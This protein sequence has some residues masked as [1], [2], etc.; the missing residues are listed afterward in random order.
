MQKNETQIIQDFI[1]LFKNIDIKKELHLIDDCI[2]LWL[3]SSSIKCRPGTIKYY[4]KYIK[5][6]KPYLNE[7][8]IYYIEDLTNIKMNL[9]ISSIKSL[10]HYKNNTINKVITTLK[11][12]THFCYI[13][14]IIDNDSLKKFQKL[15]KDDE[16]TITINKQ[17]SNKIFNYINSLD[18]HNISNLRN[19]LFIY[20]LKDTGA[21]LNELL[22]IEINNIDFKNNSILLTYTKTHDYRYVYITNITK[23]LILKFIELAKPKKYLICNEKTKKI[24]NS[25]FIYKFLN[26]IKIN[27]NIEQSISPHKWRHTLAT[28][29]L[30]ENISL[31]NIR[32]LLGHSSLEI[33]KKYL[34]LDNKYQQETILKALNTINKTEDDSEDSKESI[35]LEKNQTK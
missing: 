22:H 32:K 21:R 4:K 18:L 1:S 17:I 9:I 23:E 12:L 7:Q 10:N 14:D 31:E 34:H 35:F 27:C 16:E 29:L 2:K 5:L 30:K 20:L 26:K 3:D 13:N 33:T 24:I 15:K 19:I 8:N 25:F 28:C 6:I 11:Q